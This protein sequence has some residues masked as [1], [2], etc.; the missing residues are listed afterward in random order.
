MARG[1]LPCTQARSLAEDGLTVIAGKIYEEVLK[2]DP[3]EPDALLGM[4]LL[5]YHEDAARAITW[6]RR[7]VTVDPVAACRWSQLGTALDKSGNSLLADRAFRMAVILDPAATES[8]LGL[9][10]SL[11]DRGKPKQAAAAYRCASVLS[12]TQSE[13]HF[14]LPSLIMANKPPLRVGTRARI[15]EHSAKSALPFVLYG[16]HPESRRRVIAR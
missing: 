10:D 15:A 3:V 8:W 7:A 12:Y 2:E 13:A 16:A 11:A 6:I 14:R 5:L 9:G 1:A 4:G